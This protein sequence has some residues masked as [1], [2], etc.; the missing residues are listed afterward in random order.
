MQI[1]T[2]ISAKKDSKALHQIHLNELVKDLNSSYG[3]CQ[4]SG[5]GRLREVQ[6][7]L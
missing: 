2:I 1:L 3:R 7:D 5:A 6:G 4:Y